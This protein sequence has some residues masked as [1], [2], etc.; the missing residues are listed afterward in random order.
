MNIDEFNFIKEKYGEVA[1]W[2]V[3]SESAGGDTSDLSVFDDTHIITNVLHTR[4]VFVALNISFPIDS[5]KPFGNFH[6]GKRDFMLRDA[7]EGTPLVG[8]YMTDLIKFFPNPSASEVVRYFRKNKDL[9]DKHLEYFEEEIQF[10]GANS[11][12]TLVAVGNDAHRLLVDSGIDRKI[13]KISH[14]AAQIKK[15]EYR[16]QI[17]RLCN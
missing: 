1:S 17:L 12:T 11:E 5:E 9:L 7:I 3:W 6:G 13:V 14:Y 8:A 15:T 2:A 16:N 4:Y 10:A